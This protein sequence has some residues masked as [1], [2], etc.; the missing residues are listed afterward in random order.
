MYHAGLLFQCSLGHTDEAALRPV[1]I[2]FLTNQVTAT[3]VLIDAVTADVNGIG[4]N[5]GVVILTI[6]GRNKTIP[7][8]IEKRWIK[9]KTETDSIYKAVVIPTLQNQKWFCFDMG[10]YDTK[11]RLCE[12]AMGVKMKKVGA[13]SHPMELP[14]MRQNK[15]F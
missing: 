11:G 12:M 13:I 3:A 4:M 6:I 5:T 10:I 7:I 14:S 1:A 9:T 8:E 15:T 2:I